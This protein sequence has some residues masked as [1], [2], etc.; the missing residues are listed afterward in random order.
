MLDLADHM[1]AANKDAYINQL[2]NELSRM[3]LCCMCTVTLGISSLLFYISTLKVIFLY[4]YV[5]LFL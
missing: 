5:F 2:K 3:V 1:S 4:T